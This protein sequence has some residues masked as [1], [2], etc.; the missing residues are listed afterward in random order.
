MPFGKALNSVKRYIIIKVV[1]DLEEFEHQV[2]KK[3]AEGYTP[4]G[5]VSLHTDVTS[6]NDEF[7]QALYLETPNGG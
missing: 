6:R 7:C 2:N 1:Q 3:I 4:L 5:G